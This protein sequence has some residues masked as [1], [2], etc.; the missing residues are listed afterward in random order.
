[1]ISSLLE[2]Q[3]LSNTSFSIP[4]VIGLM[5]PSGGGGEY[6][7]LIFK[8][9]ATNV[10]SA[11]RISMPNW[12]A[13]LGSDLPHQLTANETRSDLRRCGLVHRQRKNRGTIFA[14]RCLRQHDQLIIGELYYL[15][16]LRLRQPA[17]SPA[18]PRKGARGQRGR[19]GARFSASARNTKQ[20][21]APHRSPATSH[22]HCLQCAKV[23]LCA[24]RKTND[25]K[26]P[27]GWAIHSG[28]RESFRKAG[29]SQ[30]NRNKG[31]PH[32]SG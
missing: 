25:R 3:R 27:L 17:L 5:K 8:I 24:R 23:H 1:M 2:R 12:H 15:L 30:R 32:P 13:R 31:Q 14:C 9:C 19:G 10:G 20:C 26:C 18:R 28:D 6:E 11:I 7:E 16:L 21:S 4:H 22:G 29:G